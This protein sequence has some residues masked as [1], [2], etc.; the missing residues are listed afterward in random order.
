MH[1]ADFFVGHFGLLSTHKVLSPVLLS[2]IGYFQQNRPH[3]SSFVSNSFFEDGSKFR[4][5]SPQCV[6]LL[7]CAC[8]TWKTC[9]SLRIKT[10]E[11]TF[12]RL[13]PSGCILGKAMFHVQFFARC[14]SLSSLNHVTLFCKKDD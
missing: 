6:W 5:P 4:A 8:A 2:S 1:H 12:L 14:E 11:K 10:K 13:N 7:V 9:S 3:E